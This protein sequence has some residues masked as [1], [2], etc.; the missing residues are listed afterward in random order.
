MKLIAFLM[1]LF[2]GSY[3]HAD[4][5][6]SWLGHR[7]S[8]LYL[9]VIYSKGCYEGDLILEFSKYSKNGPKWPSPNVR[10]ESIPFERECGSS[11]KNKTGEVVEFSC[12]NDGV[13][14]LAGATYRY[15]QVK[16]TRRCDGIDEPDWDL[17]FVCISG[18]GLT[19]PK[20]LE[21]RHG[22]GCS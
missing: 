19:T 20:K 17:S 5:Q 1:L 16:T 13:S 22:E 12:R 8:T 15:K 14:P 7:S 11:K 18:C 9:S 21:V 6:D 3:A 4:C 2:V 10:L